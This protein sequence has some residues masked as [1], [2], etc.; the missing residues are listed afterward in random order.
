MVLSDA[1][2]IERRGAIVRLLRA[3]SVRRQADLVRLLKKEGYDAT[4]SSI[5]RDLRDLGVLKASGRYVLA[6][7]EV[8]RANG[9]FGT[10]AQF[11]RQLRRAGPAITVLRTTIGAAQS[12]AVA[13]DRA[14]WPEVAGTLSG[15]DTIFIATA[16]ARAQD[17][18]IGRLRSLFRV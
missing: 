16:S 4:Q 14:E 12:V 9:D 8:T 11:V 13:I 6:P 15:D 18:L 2:Q 17:E 5:S 7:D 3:G 1:Q 10:L